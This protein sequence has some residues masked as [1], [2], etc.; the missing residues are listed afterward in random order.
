VK[1]L[2]RGAVAMRWARHNLRGVRKVSLQ[3]GCNFR[4]GA[5]WGHLAVRAG[6]PALL[7]HYTLLP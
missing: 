4:L 6:L 1:K 7:R 5:A 2:R 3:L